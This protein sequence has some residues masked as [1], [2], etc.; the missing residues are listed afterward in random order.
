MVTPG[1]PSCCLASSSA[2]NRTRFRHRMVRLAPMPPSRSQKGPPETED[3]TVM[4]EQTVYHKQRQPSQ[5]SDDGPVDPDELQ[6]LTDLILDDLR[7]GYRVPVLHHASHI[8]TDLSPVYFDRLPG[9]PCE[10]GIDSAAQF[11]VHDHGIADRGQLLGCE[12]VDIFTR[13]GHTL[14]R[15]KP[16]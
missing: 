6:V 2:T 12:F 10:I 14:H 4:L 3:A 8:W 15:P 7:H 1:D 16:Q 13:C 11:I 5:S 9:N